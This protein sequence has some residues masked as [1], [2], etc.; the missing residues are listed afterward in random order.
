[1]PGGLPAVRLRVQFDR[2]VPPQA[3]AIFPAKEEVTVSYSGG[4]FQGRRV[5]PWSPCAPS[6][7]TSGLPLKQPVLSPV[8]GAALYA[9]ILDNPE[10]E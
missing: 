3:A 7:R 9:L 1:M 4:V 2:E 5:D 8:S 10:A 6:S